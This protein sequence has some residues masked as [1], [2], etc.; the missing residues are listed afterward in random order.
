MADAEAQLKK[1]RKLEANRICPNCGSPSPTGLG[2]GNICMKYLTFICDSC[3][4][5]HQAIS[6]RC[7]SVAMSA[8]T[9][10]E[11]LSLTTQQGGGN[12]IALRTWLA[13]AP[14]I[15]DRYPGGKRPQK[16]DKIDIFKQFVIDCYEK[17]MFYGDGSEAVCPPERSFSAPP[18]QQTQV[19]ACNLVSFED[20]TDMPVQTSSGVG[21]DAFGG[22]NGEGG[23]GFDAFSD[24]PT[25]AASGGFSSPSGGFDF[26][27]FDKAP[28]APAS[29]AKATIDP[30]AFSGIQSAPLA[31]PPALQTYSSAP[32]RISMNDI[33][34]FAKPS[35]TPVTSSAP[36]GSYSSS[37]TASM[38]VSLASMSLNS[39]SSA[40]APPQPVASGGAF[41]VFG[42]TEVLTLQPTSTGL[43][44][45]PIPQQRPNISNMMPSQTRTGIGNNPNA[46]MA[47]SSLGMGTPPG[48][49]QRGSSLGNPGAFDFVGSAMRS[50]LGSRGG[51]ASSPS[52][53]QGMGGGMGIGAMNGTGN[54]SISGMGVSQQQMRPSMQ[55]PNSDPFSF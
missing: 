49:P 28:P 2:F 45:G 52:L 35:A 15:G 8:W 13:R 1:V 32:G 23:A 46:A 36:I 34:P 42:S 41:D 3:K 29:A 48:G 10:E 37:S 18:A 31:P 30:F 20:D 21:F 27:A 9:M 44:G 22:S 12:E 11:V 55:Q 43:S 40:M 38:G 53:Q 6:H 54:L 19:Q 16:G 4:S 51:S 24:S 39:A 26:S 50:E 14:P 7:K 17:R 33:D 5:S 25:T 47:I